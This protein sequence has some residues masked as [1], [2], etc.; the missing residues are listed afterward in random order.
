[1]AAFVNSYT[2]RQGLPALVMKDLISRSSDIPEDA[3][4]MFLTVKID[5]FI[6][7]LQRHGHTLSF[8]RAFDIDGNDRFWRMN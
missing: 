6:K 2:L 3:P 5:S 7:K 8:L 1:M 4:A